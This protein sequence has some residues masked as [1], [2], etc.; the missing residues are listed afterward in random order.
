MRI[1][2]SPLPSSPLPPPP[3]S[4]IFAFIGPVFCLCVAGCRRRRTEQH[5]DSL[6]TEK[7]ASADSG[8]TAEGTGGWGGEAAWCGRKNSGFGAREARV[9]ILTLF[10]SLT[11]A[12]D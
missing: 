1:R 7:G 8:G 4:P 10:F 3:G 5:G 6:G 11:L 9:L 2:T 12:S